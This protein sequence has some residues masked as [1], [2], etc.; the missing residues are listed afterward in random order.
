ML[1]LTIVD[2]SLHQRSSHSFPTTLGIRSRPRCAILWLALASLSRIQHSSPCSLRVSC[3]QQLAQPD[4]HR[5]VRR[6][7]RYQLTR[8]GVAAV[9]LYR[10]DQLHGLASALWR[11][12][13]TGSMVAREVW[14]GCQLGFSG[15][16]LAIDLLCF[17][18]G[19][20]ES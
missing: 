5:L 2:F 1:R 20:C 11:T 15:V 7:Q 4:Q 3:H 18:A 14:T 8:R 17:L 13:A 12:T 6:T 19:D 9:L 10:D 16:H